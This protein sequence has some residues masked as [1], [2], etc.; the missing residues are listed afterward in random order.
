[1]NCQWAKPLGMAST[2]V[3][4]DDEHSYERSTS[5]NLFIL[6][7]SMRY[8]LRTPN[9][10]LPIVASIIARGSWT[11][12]SRNSSDYSQVST[13]YRL[14]NF[15][16]THHMSPSI[17]SD[18]A[19][20]GT[21]DADKRCKSERVPASAIVALRKNLFGGDVLG[22]ESQKKNDYEEGYDVQNELLDESMDEP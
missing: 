4:V 17:G 15:Q 1:M 19:S 2:R 16:P 5:S 13:S 10:P 21:C 14:E 22:E 6:A 7:G 12:A 8:H 20:Q 9:R 18:E 11:D 3:P